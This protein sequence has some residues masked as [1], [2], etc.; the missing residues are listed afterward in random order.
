MTPTAVADTQLGLP[1]GELALLRQH[2]NLAMGAG[3]VAA[4]RGP[5]SHYSYSSASTRGRGTARS[6]T[7]SS[8]AASAASSA[9]GQGQRLMLDAG[10]LSVLGAYFDRLM[11]RIQD[12]MD[13]VSSSIQA[14]PLALS[15]RCSSRGAC[16][17][18]D[19]RTGK[20][21]ATVFVRN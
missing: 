19:G 7:V 10:S 18:S 14:F 8:R 9:G 11:G 5:S 6:S 16:D 2:H 12:R 21:M 4:A 13:Y 20:V 3:A 1:P 15:F 17:L